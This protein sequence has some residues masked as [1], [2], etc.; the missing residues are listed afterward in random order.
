[1]KFQS[2]RRVLAA[3]ASGL[4]L[5][6]ASLATQAALIVPVGS[7][8]DFGL[9]GEVSGHTVLHS[10]AFDGSTKQFTRTIAN[11]GPTLNMALTESQTDLGN[12]QFRILF[13]VTA[14]GD[15]FPA[16]AAPNNPEYGL[17]AMGYQGDPL[18]LL[19]ALTLQS[20]IVRVINGA[21]SV[22]ADGDFIA[23]VDQTEPWDGVFT[24]PGFLAGYGNAG[25]HDIRRLQLELVVGPA[26]NDVPEPQ[27]LL[28]AG[29]A[30]AAAAA[31]RRR[32]PR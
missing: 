2:F 9:L 18:N 10:V 26:V 24:K 32:R 11:G 1:M 15:M 21:G 12:G 5:A 19:E 27:S 6:G 17:V 7:T 28:L 25:A 13:D 4:V 23:Y 14:D 20:A 3:L 22:L 29:L 31:A 8:Y 16:M 30:L